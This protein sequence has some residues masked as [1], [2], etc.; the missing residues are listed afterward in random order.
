MSSKTIICLCLIAAIFALINSS[1][2][3]YLYESGYP[4]S[5]TAYGYGNGY[6]GS[7]GVYPYAAYNGYSGYSGYYGK[8][9][10]GF[11]STN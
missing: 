3:Q 11:G 2:A 9:A 7:N 1:S 4:Y 10:A 8:R 5:A 6:Y